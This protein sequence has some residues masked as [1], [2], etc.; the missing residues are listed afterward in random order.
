MDKNI[1]I[2]VPMINRSLMELEW[3]ESEQIM[4]E[5]LFL[6]EQCSQ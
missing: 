5:F 2:C 1:L 3:Q 6:G 4:T